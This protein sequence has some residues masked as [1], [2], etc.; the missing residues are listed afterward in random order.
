MR[1]NSIGKV[2]KPP[3]AHSHDLSKRDV[4]RSQKRWRSNWLHWRSQS[5]LMVIKSKEAWSETKSP[6]VIW[7]GNA[8]KEMMTFNHMRQVGEEVMVITYAIKKKNKMWSRSATV[9]PTL[10]FYRE[11]GLVFFVELRVFL[12][13]CGLLLFRHVS[14]DICLF[15]GLFF[16]RFMFCG[17]FFFQ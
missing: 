2:E 17:L 15:F 8:N 10:R 5:I 6:D 11:F 12:K 7:L 14:I 9:L 16:C 1:H 13:A 3:T 4:A